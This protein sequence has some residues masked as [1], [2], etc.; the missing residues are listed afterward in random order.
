MNVID[1]NDTVLLSNL[2]LSFENALKVKLRRKEPKAP[3]AA[4]SAPDVIKEVNFAEVLAAYVDGLMR[5]EYKE[6]DHDSESVNSQTS[7]NSISVF[8]AA[9]CRTWACRTASYRSVAVV[10]RSCSGARIRTFTP[11]ATDRATTVAKPRGCKAR[12]VRFARGGRSWRSN[13]MCTLKT[14]DGR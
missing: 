2:K 13:F 5:R 11:T 8:F 6:L 12:P 1:E 4:E 3:G 14:P 9:F 7:A 10:S